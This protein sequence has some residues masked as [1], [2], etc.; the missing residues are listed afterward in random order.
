MAISLED[1]LL[2]RAP[3]ATSSYSNAA[4]KESSIFDAIT[5]RGLS[6]SQ[7]DQTDSL[8]KAVIEGAK[9]RDIEPDYAL[10][11]MQQESGFNPSIGNGGLGQFT[12]GTALS[13]G[14][15]YGR[16]NTDPQYN[17]DSSL[18]YLAALRKSGG[19]DIREGLKLYNWGG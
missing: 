6:L 19:G 5:E 1:I 15:D 3:A 9:K 13:R 11:M 4:Q 14:L 16:L 12:K 8:H 7:Q 17:I 18:D 2:S 10:A